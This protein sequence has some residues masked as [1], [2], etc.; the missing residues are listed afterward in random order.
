MMTDSRET[1]APVFAANSDTVTTP[2]ADMD[3]RYLARIRSLAI[4]PLL[5]ENA[6]LKIVFVNLRGAGDPIIVSLLRG[7]GIDVTVVPGQ[8]TPDEKFPT[9][10]IADP[11]DN[12]LL[13]TAIELAGRSDA[14]I[15]IATDT[16]R[17]AAAARGSNG[18]LSWLTSNQIGALIGW[19]RLKTCFE[20]G[21]LTDATRSRAIILK[22]FL[23]SDLQRAIADEFGV[24]IVDTLTGS[25]HFAA[26]LRKYEDAIPAAKKGDYQSLD[27]KQTRLLRL[28]YSRFLVFGGDE[29]YGYLG[30]DAI[31]DKDANGAALM[32][33]EVAAYAQSI[34][35]TI[36]GLLDAIYAEFGYHAET[37]KSIMME[38]AEG[39]VRI[40]QLAASY[41]NNPPAVAD[42]CAVTRLRDFATED[43]YDQEG[44]LLPKGNMLI[45]D[46][47]DGRSFAVRPSNTESKINYYLFG[48]ALPGGDLV[49]IKTHVHAGL[50]RLWT[51]IQTDAAARQGDA[52][53]GGLNEGP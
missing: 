11:D 36:P 13:Q 19:Y 42:G 18:K 40:Q 49:A 32:F 28:E 50:D 15:V 24:G 6:S 30:S 35:R 3:D 12:P 45:V 14:P 31:R 39:A 26:K 33:A 41:A 10:A 8:H 43:I 7:Y 16:H 9:A 17:M 4:R 1:C 44:D 22:T 34:N 52:F 51:W 53:H 47:A 5:L 2:N 27:E 20:I 46:L 29:N 23:T 21:W 48:R 38:G 25:N 37:G